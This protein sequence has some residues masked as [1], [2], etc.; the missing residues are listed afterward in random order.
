MQRRKR[1]GETQM[2]TQVTVNGK[3]VQV[4]VRRME[5]GGYSCV[6]AWNRIETPSH[7]YCAKGKGATERE[8][9]F[10]F[11]EANRLVTIGS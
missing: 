2:K 3:T 11:I 8:A 9:I 10:A 1:K 5:L 7:D 6:K 4:L